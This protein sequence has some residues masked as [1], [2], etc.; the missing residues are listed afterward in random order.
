MRPPYIVEVRPP[1][2]AF[3]R[4]GLKTVMPPPDMY[5]Y[6]HSAQKQAR[7]LSCTPT[8]LII[9]NYISIIIVVVAL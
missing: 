8:H 7:R 2:M 3:S 1:K 4:S 6:T 9:L 5:D